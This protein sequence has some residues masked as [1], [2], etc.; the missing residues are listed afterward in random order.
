[1]PGQREPHRKMTADGACAENAY[2][3]GVGCQ[4]SA[5]TDS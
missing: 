4:E 1:M 3:H 2:P 5:L